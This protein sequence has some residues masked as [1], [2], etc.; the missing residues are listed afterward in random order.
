MITLNTC[1]D[2]VVMTV[3]GVAG[4]TPP[5]GVEG[6]GLGAGV[7]GFGFAG[8]DGL[9]WLASGT[10]WLASEVLGFPGVESFC[11]G[12]IFIC[13]KYCLAASLSWA[14]NFDALLSAARFPIFTCHVDDPQSLEQD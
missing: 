3:P 5:A 10:A 8:V 9:G 13:S 7:P 2:L 11:K 14:T 1:V 6:L 12:L 4:W